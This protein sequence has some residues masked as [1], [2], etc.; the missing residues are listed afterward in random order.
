MSNCNAAFSWLLL[1]RRCAYII[2]FAWLINDETPGLHRPHDSLTG[3][4]RGLQTL[5]SAFKAFRPQIEAWLEDSESSMQITMTI[6]LSIRI[7]QQLSSAAVTDFN[8]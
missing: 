1:C 7:D 6:A 2:S 8:S 5:L 3:V 4:A